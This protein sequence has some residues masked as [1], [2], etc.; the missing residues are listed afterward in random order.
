MRAVENNDARAIFDIRDDIII[1]SNSTCF[2]YAVRLDF[3][4]HWLNVKVR[5]HSVQ[6]L[7]VF[8]IRP[9]LNSA[10]VR[11]GYADNYD[12]AV[13]HNLLKSLVNHF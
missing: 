11:D 8:I 2:N 7:G 4:I 10:W 6:A 1:Y 3:Y 12:R 5:A 13:R 9:S